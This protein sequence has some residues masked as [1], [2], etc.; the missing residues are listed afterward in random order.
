M[1]KDLTNVWLK[2]SGK[3][4]KGIAKDKHDRSLPRPAKISIVEKKCGKNLEE[5]KALARRRF[6]NEEMER[7]MCHEQENHA[8]KKNPTNNRKFTR[9][10]TSTKTIYTS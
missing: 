4:S 1:C 8:G 6:D 3:K 2:K 9:T 10:Q 5:N 7:E